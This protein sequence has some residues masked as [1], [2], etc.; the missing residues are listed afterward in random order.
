MQSDSIRAYQRPVDATAARH[1]EGDPPGRQGAGIA[2][3]NSC[4][5]K[6]RRKG[7]CYRRR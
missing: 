4:I 5:I 2:P 1:I 6:S 3:L 7:D